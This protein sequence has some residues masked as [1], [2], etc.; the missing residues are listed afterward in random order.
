MSKN[1]RRGIRSALR[2]FGRFC[3]EK[4][5]LTDEEIL[6]EYRKA[7]EEQLYDS[8]QDWIAW[9]DRRGVGPSSIRMHFSHL[10]KYLRHQR[11]RITNEDARE[12]LRFPH[13]IKEEKHPLTKDEI[14]RILA[15]SRNNTRLRILAQTSSG[16]RRGELLQ[17]RKR[18]LDMSQRR[19]A[20]HVRSETVKTRRSRVT[21]FSR[22]VTPLL[23]RITRNL[24]EDDRVFSSGTLDVKS[25]GANY[26]D[27][28]VRCLERCGLDK[29][30]SAG[31]HEISTHSFRAFFITRVSRHDPNLAKYFAGQEQSGDLLVYDRLT[32]DERLE[33]YIEFEPDLLT[34]DP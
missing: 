10:K 33:K 31:R 2:N 12:H 8:L 26:Q 25:T 34:S 14:R 4:Y 9:N 29:R 19:I 7:T 27:T 17:L 5:G 23:S 16:L 18:D 13:Q 24:G 11:I 30:N 3:Q 1:T 20:V 22:E 32:L 28:L 6:A 21:F 15:A